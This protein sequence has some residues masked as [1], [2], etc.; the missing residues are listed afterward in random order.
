[1]RKETHDGSAGEQQN[2]C[3]AVKVGVLHA[4]LRQFAL[5]PG[6]DATICR[7]LAMPELFNA[8]GA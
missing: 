1:M 7:T 2:R 3:H 4:E 6:A 8:L 5:L